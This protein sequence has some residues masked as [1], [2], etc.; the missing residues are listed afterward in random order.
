MYKIIIFILSL[1]LYN[2]VIPYIVISFKGNN[3]SLIY[4]NSKK[5]D[6]LE[7]FIMS[8]FYNQL[9]TAIG[10]GNPKQNV[11]LNIIPNQ[12][13]F[14]FNK[15]NCLFFYNNDYIDKNNLCP[16]NNSTPINISKIGYN[17]NLSKSFSK[18]NNTNLPLY[19]K[20]NNYYFAK[21]NVKIDDYRDILTIN[22]NKTK[23][24]P[25][26]QYHLVNF[27]FVYEEIDINDENEN[28][29]ICG[30]IGLHLYDSKNNNKFIEQ[31]KYSN[32]TNN[33]YWSFNYS[34]MDKGIMIF[35]I[36]PHEYYPNEYNSYNLEETYSLYDEGDMKWAMYLNDIYFY[37]KKNKKISIQSA[38]AEGEFEFA[39]QLIIGSSSYKELIKKHFFQDYFNKGICTE[40]EYK[41]DINYFIV[42]CKKET[43]QKNIHKFPDLFLY[44]R[45]LQ[46]TFDLSYKDLFITIGEYIYF[47]VIFR[48]EGKYPNQTWKLGIPFLKKHQ[49]IFNTDSKRIGYYVKNKINYTN[50]I[51]NNNKHNKENKE[52]KNSNGI[53]KN[54]KEFISLRTSLEIIIIV[55]FIIILI[56]FGK[57][58]Y[59]FK[60]KQKK[61]YE[62]QDEDYDYYSDNYSYNTNKKKDNCDINK[63]LDDDNSSK[64][65]IIEMKI[66]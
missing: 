57:Q 58:L 14:L 52:N 65:K 44:N 25:N 31:L 2:K 5:K 33:Y 22:S 23:I 3:L 61:P 60:T 29:E 34:S 26:C 19:Y 54:I 47:L 32:I 9:Y 13:D 55:I 56:Y 17:K 36:L 62:L 15:M 50:N 43:F 63:K 28:N 38:I 16:N 48:K 20:N 41:L 18:N 30:S 45:G 39:M 64:G 59:N 51:K 40:E 12:V 6:F 66:H 4:N 37:V 35:G 1:L 46:N 27:S 42:R 10:I 7:D 21:E 49:M 11:V 53:F 8:T 24:Y